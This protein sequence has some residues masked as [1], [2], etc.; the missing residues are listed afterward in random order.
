MAQMGNAV[1][2]FPPRAAKGTHEGARTN[3]NPIV[4]HPNTPL[5]SLP[6]LGLLSWSFNI[7]L[8]IFWAVCN[9]NPFIF[10]ALKYDFLRRHLS[11]NP[12]SASASLN[13]QRKSWSPDPPSSLTSRSGCPAQSQA[14]SCGVRR[15]LPSTVRYALAESLSSS[16]LATHV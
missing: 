16:M 7:P 5:N 6:N 4:Q 12:C 13:I 11:A 9:N 14:L 10:F 2:F 3:P 1:K 8:G 15:A